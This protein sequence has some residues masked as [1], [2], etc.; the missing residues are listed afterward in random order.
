MGVLDS[1][2]AHHYKVMMLEIADQRQHGLAAPRF[3]SPLHLS[4]EWHQPQMEA[5]ISPLAKLP[6]GGFQLL[7]LQVRPEE[8]AGVLE[9]G[10]RRRVPKYFPPLRYLAVGVGFS[11][12][13]IQRLSSRVNYMR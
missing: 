7:R 5:S 4:L 10:R 9:L 13:A 1:A 3:Y 11:F 12:T 6:A 8:G 2:H